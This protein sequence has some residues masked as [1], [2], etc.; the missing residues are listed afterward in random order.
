MNLGRTEE[1]EAMFFQAIKVNPHHS[2]AYNNLGEMY[3]RQG[4]LQEAE[5]MFR[6]ALKIHPGNVYAQKNLLKLNKTKN[7]QPSD[8][9]QIEQ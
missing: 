1:A 2:S 6:K 9:G 8:N 3:R 7:S 4:K 5:K